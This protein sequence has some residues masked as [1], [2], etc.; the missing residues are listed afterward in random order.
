MEVLLHKSLP[1]LEEKWLKEQRV[2]IPKIRERM[3]R[4]AILETSAEKRLSFD[5]LSALTED[6]VYLYGSRFTDLDY[7]KEIR[8]FWPVCDAYKRL[9]WVAVEREEERDPAR[10]LEMENFITRHLDYL[11]YY[12]FRSPNWWFNEVG[13]PLVLSYLLVFIKDFLP[14]RLYSEALTEL[15]PSSII[16]NPQY[17]LRKTGANMTWFCMLSIRH[18]ALTDNPDEIHLAIRFAAESTYGGEE[19][20]Q[21]DGSFFQHGR[22][23]YT[24]GYGRAYL[25]HFANM[26]YMLSGTSFEFP[27]GAV[28]NVVTHTLD[29]VRYMLAARSV[30]PLSCG[31]EYQRPA[32]LEIGGFALSIPMLAECEGI[33]RSDELKRLAEAIK[34]GEPTFIG[35]KY[36]DV[37]GMLVLNTGSLYF[38]FQGASDGLCTSEIINSENVLGYN[39]SYGTMTAAV[40]NGD[41]YLDPQLFDYAK[42]PG[43][44]AKNE[45]DEQLLAKP[46]FTRVPI[47]SL[48]H[49][50][51]CDGERGVCRLITAHEDVEAT[52]TAFVTPTG[53]VLLGA[54]IKCESA[55]PLTT[56]VEQ[57]RA[58]GSFRTENG[59]KT[60]VHGGI[61]YENL[62]TGSHFHAEICHK[63]ATEARNNVT[64]T[65]TP[66]SGDLF[67][68]TIP[69]DVTHP[70]YAYAITAEEDA[71]EVKVI[72]NDSAVQAILTKDGYLLAAFH[73]D[74]SLDI[75]GVTVS[76]KRGEFL[77]RKM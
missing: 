17:I 14:A 52:V 30:N 53:A 64:A 20:L 43:T 34:S 47:K 48:G 61:R 25:G 46:D 29:G 49:G 55:A 77:I 9:L 66:I 50:G 15:D 40:R 16:K 39:R 44:T 7:Y 23:L 71:A 18:G 56:T 24:C 72:R 62:D 54:D 37:A 26:L 73:K 11:L 22:L 27:K 10:R 75:D 12:K 60:V 32:G 33:P 70:S 3:K 1:H 58:K 68:L 67:L 36:F 31:R 28:S 57:S 41:E 35:A 13:V 38:A 65:P 51:K 59:G 8:A 69:V 74:T 76:G 45:T 21:S 2:D 19:G 5:E 63:E 42:M 6:S 4:L